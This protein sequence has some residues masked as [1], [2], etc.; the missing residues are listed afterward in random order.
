MKFALPHSVRRIERLA[1]LQNLRVR[2]ADDTCRGL[3]EADRIVAAALHSSQQRLDAVAQQMA[4]RQSNDGEI[5][6]RAMALAT[7]AWLSMIDFNAH[8]T[9]DREKAREDL[10]RA[11]ETRQ[12][13]R[14]K[15][16]TLHRV[17]GERV[18]AHARHHAEKLGHEVTDIWTAGQYDRNTDR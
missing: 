9:A 2:E 7:Q 5:D 11:L 6:P 13:E 3:A 17:A 4:Q 16:D 12:L 15:E 18:I 1:R 8:L 14:H 10:N